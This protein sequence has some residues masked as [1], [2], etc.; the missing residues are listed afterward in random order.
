MHVSQ[1]KLLHRILENVDS[2]VSNEG[3]AYC[4]SYVEMCTN[5]LS[6]KDT[7]QIRTVPTVPAT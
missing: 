1:E 6:N 7:S 4:P 5:Y 2:D 3:S